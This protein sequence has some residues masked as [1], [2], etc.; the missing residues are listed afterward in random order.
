MP[1][2]ELAVGYL[3]NLLYD[4][5]KKIPK[6]LND[7]YSKIY[8][9]ALEELPNKHCEVSKQQIDVFLEQENVK[10]MI[11]EYLTNPNESLFLNNMIDE[12]IN[13]F[14]IENFSQEDA[15]L[16]L[17]TF[18]DI[19]DTEIKKDS[20][21]RDYL[22]IY[23]IELINSKIDE[24]YHIITKLE[25]LEII[26]TQLDDLKITELPIERIQRDA[27]VLGSWTAFMLLIPDEIPEY[28]YTYLRGACSRLGIPKQIVKNYEKYMREHQITPSNPFPSL[29]M[30]KITQE[31]LYSVGLSSP[32]NA[33]I[34]NHARLLTMNWM[35][36]E[37]YSKPKSTFSHDGGEIEKFIEMIYMQNAE[38]D[39]IKESLL[40]N[41]KT[42]LYELNIKFDEV[43]KLSMIALNNGSFKDPSYYNKK[44][45]EM[46]PEI[47]R[48]LLKTIFPFYGDD[49]Y[50]TMSPEEVFEI[51]TK[52]A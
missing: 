41:V 20:E 29:E 42:D 23:I 34:F 17:K 28:V 32:D 49:A 47:R 9:K 2:S 18:F 15:D 4:T 31:F 46:E 10:K 5:S 1:L 43:G 37:N 51:L 38:F 45:G 19:I 40:G 24:L 12:F 36:I 7:T 22:I 14:G 3:V 39:A 48:K 50:P 27:V 26:A 44:L 13:L 21:L 25:N 8:D 33:H 30:L 16:I 11:R 52:R 6:K 35:L